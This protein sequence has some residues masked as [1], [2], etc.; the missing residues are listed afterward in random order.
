MRDEKS[1]ALLAVV[2]LTEPKQWFVAGLTDHDAVYGAV[3]FI[4]AAKAQG[5]RPVLGAELTLADGH[6]LTLLVENEAGW[7]NLCYLISRSR[8]N[9]PK[10]AA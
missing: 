3:R 8:H 4:E 1:P 2:I 6:H 9:A 10:G 7:H 5:V